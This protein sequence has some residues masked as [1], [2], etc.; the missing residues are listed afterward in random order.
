V[1]APPSGCWT[2]VSC[3]ISYRE[4]PLQ[5]K[6]W[7][8][9]LLTWLA[10]VKGV[11]SLC[12]RGF[13]LSRE[14]RF[15]GERND[16]GMLRWGMRVR[17]SSVGSFFLRRSGV[18]LRSFSAFPA[19]LAVPSRLIARN[20]NAI[21]LAARGYL[22]SEVALRCYSVERIIPKDTTRFSANPLDRCAS[23]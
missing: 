16:A 12:K 6:S 21:Y 7:R 20:R 13:R 9:G 14:T 23:S 8:L 4:I 10:R 3:W 5:D 18:S 2:R 22:V 1:A 15:I 11:L 19:S 17:C